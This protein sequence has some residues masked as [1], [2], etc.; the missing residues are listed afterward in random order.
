MQNEKVK[1]LKTING[2]LSFLIMIT[3][4]LSVTLIGQLILQ[5]VGIT[6]GLLYYAISGLFSSISIIAVIIINGIKMT[7]QV[8]KEST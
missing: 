2:G 3:V 6:T 5:L 1:N 8:P 4:Y 7:Y